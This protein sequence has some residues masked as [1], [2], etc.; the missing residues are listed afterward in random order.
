M[1]LSCLLQVNAMSRMCIERR[2]GHI[3]VW[4]GTFRDSCVP[5][6]Q[7]VVQEVMDRLPG[8]SH[9]RNEA[10]LTIVKVRASLQ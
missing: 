10:L 3:N 1:S 2:L 5:Y 9:S 8:I 6:A 7:T 4:S